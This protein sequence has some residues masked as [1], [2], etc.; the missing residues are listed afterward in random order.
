MR[1]ESWLYFL[2]LLE[3]NSIIIIASFRIDVK[4]E[5]NTTVPK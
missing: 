5:P 1:N 2:A 4:K 3:K